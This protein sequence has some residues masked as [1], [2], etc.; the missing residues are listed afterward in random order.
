MFRSDL[1]L[2]I[3]DRNYERIKNDTKWTYD[4]YELMLNERFDGTTIN[5][6]NKGL[7]R[8]LVRM[9]S[10]LNI[11]TQWYWKTDLLN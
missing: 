1:R 6:N 7:G 5:E 10:T 3:S 2:V 9:N 8:E 4:N 11:Y